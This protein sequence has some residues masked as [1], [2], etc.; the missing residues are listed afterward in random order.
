MNLNKWFALMTIIIGWIALGSFDRLAEMESQADRQIPFTPNGDRMAQS[1]RTT[2]VL[3]FPIVWKDYSI[4]RPTPTRS[5]TLTPT[6]TKTVIPTFTWTPFPTSSTS[7]IINTGKVVITRIVYNGSGDHEPDEFVEIRNDEE[8]VIQLYHWTLS[9]QEEHV[10]IFPNYY[11]FPGQVCRI[12][13]NTS[14]EDLC[15]FSYGSTS[16]IWDNKG[17][18]ATLKDSSDHFID[19]YEY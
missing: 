11:L 1:V 14:I 13:T 7:H 12:F 6:W 5:I 9:D 18:K 16:E 4:F 17:D 3:F 10:F 8:S 19:D 15:S 2:P